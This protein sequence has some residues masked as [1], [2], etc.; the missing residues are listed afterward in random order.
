MRKNQIM[1][2]CGI[3][4]DQQGIIKVGKITGYNDYGIP[5]RRFHWVE[6]KL[7]EL[8]GKSFE[9]FEDQI[10]YAHNRCSSL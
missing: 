10:E 2:I 6:P 1:E 7:S 9:A 5:A 8:K 3:F 4:P